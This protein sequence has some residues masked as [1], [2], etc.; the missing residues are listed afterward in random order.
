MMLT[1]LSTSYKWNHSVFV[2]LWF[3]SLSIVSS[4]F[5]HV[6]VLELS[7]LS[8]LNNISLCMYHILLICSSIHMHLGCFH[9]LAIVKNTAMNM[10]IQYLFETCFWL[11]HPKVELLDHIGILFLIFWGTTI[12]SSTAAVPF[13]FPP[14]EHEGS[15]CSI[16]LPT[17]VIFWGFSW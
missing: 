11:F 9:I 14:T 1:T 15:N 2:Y 16:A 10:G 17:F 8:R 7:S 4:R 3:L 12:L 13:I 6:V 5:T